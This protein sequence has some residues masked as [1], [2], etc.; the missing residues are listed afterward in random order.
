MN[1]SNK[2]IPKKSPFKKCTKFICENM[3]NRR[4]TCGILFPSG[5]VAVGDDVWRMSNTADFCEEPFKIYKNTIELE[6]KYRILEAPTTKFYDS[7][8]RSC[9]LC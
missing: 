1:Y 5:K 3:E 9:G 2:K 6:K 7:R 8:E 4:K